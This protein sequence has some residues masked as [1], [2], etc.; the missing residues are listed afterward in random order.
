MTG[1]YDFAAGAQEICARLIRTQSE[2]IHRGASLVAEALRNDGI[3]QAFGTGHSR[4]LAMEIAGRAGG[5]VPTN[6]LMLSDLAFS[7][8]L[9]MDRARDPLLE[10]DPE[11]AQLLWDLHK[12]RGSDVVVI[13]SNSGGNGAIVEFAQIAKR[14]GCPLIAVTSVSHSSEIDSRHPSGR[15]LMEEADVVID[16]CGPFGDA[17]VEVEEGVRACGVSTISSALAVQMM[18]AETL[19]LLA[20]SGDELPIYRSAN[21]PGGDEHNQRLRARYGD[22]I[23]TGDA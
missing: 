17:I 7:G 13:G 12:I 2:A 23:H 1:M 15:K 5:L 10:R 22:R 14:Q 19:E 18:V 16:N 4:A 8:D 9:P 21:I 11:V 6:R 20:R 3:V